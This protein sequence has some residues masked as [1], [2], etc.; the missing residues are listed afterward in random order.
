MHFF[1]SKSYRFFIK[2]RLNNERAVHAQEVNEYQQTI[3]SLQKKIAD[4]NK[5]HAKAMDELKYERLKY[6]K[7]IIPRPISVPEFP[8]VFI[9]L[10]K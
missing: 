8:S 6:Q 4:M 3:N 2:K 7:R 10:I 5:Q 1:H 9:F